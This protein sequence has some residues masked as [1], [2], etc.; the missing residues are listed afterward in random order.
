M[1]LPLQTIILLQIKIYQIKVYVNVRSMQKMVQNQR[2]QGLNENLH[3][4]NIVHHENIHI[5]Y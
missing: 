2:S 3:L 1:L 4:Q 5:D